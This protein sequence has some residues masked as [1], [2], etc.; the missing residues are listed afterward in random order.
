MAWIYLE[1]LSKQFMIS[2]MVDM[3]IER[4]KRNKARP[5][6]NIA[7]MKSWIHVFLSG[8]AV[9]EGFGGCSTCLNAHQPVSQLSSFFSGPCPGRTLRQFQAYVSTRYCP[10]GSALQWFCSCNRPLLGFPVSA[11]LHL[12]SCFLALVL[13][14]M[15]TQ[16]DQTLMQV[17][18]QDFLENH[19]PLSS[20]G[21]SCAWYL[22]F[23]RISFTALLSQFYYAL[24]HTVLQPL[25]PTQS[26]PHFEMFLEF[27][28]T[29]QFLH[30]VHQKNKLHLAYSSF[31]HQQK[32]NLICLNQ[33]PPTTSQASWNPAL[34]LNEH[35]AP[36][37]L[38]KK[39]LPFETDFH[40]QISNGILMQ[41]LAS[42]TSKI[43]WI[44]SVTAWFMY[45]MVPFT[46]ARLFSP[47]HFPLPN[48][49]FFSFPSQ[50]EF[51]RPSLLFLF[52]RDSVSFLT[53]AHKTHAEHLHQK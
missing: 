15:H 24:F 52:A 47:H 2:W 43:S 39:I 36:E 28:I 12:K 23:S 53:A 14:H 50:T 34:T 9:V 27:A 35:G 22:Y 13:V 17:T 38:S 8:L 51:P 6:C 18:F 21:V 25:G 20:V 29:P 37:F 45:H 48:K 7:N 3:E 19:L 33:W 41:E 26:L 16:R 4:S 10:S 31:Y 32:S 42:K 1:M 46:A 30:C 49:F 5:K 11:K 44:L 40:S